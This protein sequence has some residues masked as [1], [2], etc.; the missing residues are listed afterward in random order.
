MYHF[1]KEVF[2]LSVRIAATVLPCFLSI[3][4]I[5]YDFAVRRPDG[6]NLPHFI[7]AQVTAKSFHGASCVRIY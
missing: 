1:R 2:V 5:G 4:Q 7:C 6:Y 3:I